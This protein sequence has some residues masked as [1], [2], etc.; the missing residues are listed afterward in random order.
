M[1]SRGAKVITGCRD[2][3]K[4]ESVVKIVKDKYKMDVVVE[5]LDLADLASV[6]KFAARCLKE[7]RID[8]LVNNAGLM[9]PKHGAGTKQG[10]EMHF[11]V[12]YLGHYLLTSMLYPLMAKTGTQT[13]PS[14]LINVSSSGYQSVTWPPLHCHL[15]TLSTLGSHCGKVWMWMLPTLATQAGLTQAGQH[16]IGC[17]D[18]ANWLRSTM[19]GWTIMIML[20]IM[21]YDVM[22]L[23]R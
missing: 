11:G 6:K 2:L 1:A 8:I 10:L 13:R 5:P 12:N 21:G 7:S 23:G 17:M 22:M 20:M 16:S 14:R 4:A 19:P 9:M 15:L 3:K 18:R